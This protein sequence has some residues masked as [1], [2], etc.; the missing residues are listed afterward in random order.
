MPDCTPFSICSASSAEKRP[1]E[2]PD[3]K[4]V[5]SWHGSFCTAGF[6]WKLENFSGYVWTLV[7]NAIFSYC[8]I[9]ASDGHNTLA[10]CLVPIHMLAHILKTIIHLF[11]H[12][13]LADYG[14]PGILLPEVEFCSLTTVLQNPSW[15]PI[16]I[17]SGCLT[18]CTCWKTKLKDKIER[19]NCRIDLI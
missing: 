16:S 15:P 13:Q 14:R 3:L 4:D 5:I 17:N 9:L 6:V 12:T 1:R 18:G 10:N 19:Q 8:H 2:I 7:N 11:S